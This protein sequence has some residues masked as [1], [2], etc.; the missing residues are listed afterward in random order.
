MLYIIYLKE[1]KNAYKGV[2]FLLQGDFIKL[3]LRIHSVPIICGLHKY[4]PHVEIEPLK[5]LHRLCSL[6]MHAV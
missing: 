4:L 6:H 2:K 3:K 1:L 5:P